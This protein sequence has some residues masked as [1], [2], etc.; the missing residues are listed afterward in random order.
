MK[1]YIDLKNKAD[2]ISELIRQR[3]TFIRQIADMYH[4]RLATPTEIDALR[5]QAGEALQN[6]A[7]VA[8]LLAAVAA[9]NA[10]VATAQPKAAIVEIPVA[11]PSDDDKSTAKKLMG[12]VSDV[13]RNEPDWAKPVNGI[14]ARLRLERNRENNGTPILAA[15]LEL[16]NVSNSATP[17]EI[18][19]DS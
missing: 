11:V 17:I 13:L 16:Q 10:G 9:P 7:A 18:A 4:R 5:K 2:F 15:F 8:R 3:K 1:R 6:D 19:L 14:K 12:A